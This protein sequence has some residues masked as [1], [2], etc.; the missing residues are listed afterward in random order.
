[1]VVMSP[2][3]DELDWRALWWHHAS[4]METCLHWSPLATTGLLWVEFLPDMKF[5]MWIRKSVT[6]ASTY[7]SRYFIFEWTIPLSMLSIL[8]RKLDWQTVT[9]MQAAV[10]VV[11]LMKM[12]N[13]EGNPWN[14]AGPLLSRAS[15]FSRVQQ[16]RSFWITW[17]GFFGVFWTKHC[18]E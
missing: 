11:V 14:S 9:I 12:T 7:S 17:L 13:K 18:L 5:K 4:S 3:G 2:S 6:R 1:M 8:T 16:R 15:A 10:C